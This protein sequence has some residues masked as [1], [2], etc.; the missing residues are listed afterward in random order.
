MKKSELISELSSSKN[1]SIKD[2]DAVITIIIQEITKALK[3]EGR[4]E[5]RGFGVF[6]SKIR[7]ERE[8]RNPKRK[9]RSFISKR[10]TIRGMTTKSVSL[11][12]VAKV[13][14]TKYWF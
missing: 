14:I 13:G 6:S 11:C 4:A 1:L 5:F 7:N 3:L 10:L 2:A 8:G 12:C 9:T